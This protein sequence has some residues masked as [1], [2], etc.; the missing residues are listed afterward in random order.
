VV[1]TPAPPAVVVVYEDI[2]AY[3]L[4]EQALEHRA[5]HDDLTDLPNRTLFADRLEQAMRTAAREHKALAVIIMDLDRFKD[6]NDTFGHEYGDHLLR[7]VGQR[8]RETVRQS[9]T[10]A[11]MGGDEFGI[12]L[13]GITQRRQATIAARKVLSVFET[14]FE[15]EGHSL[16]VGASLGIAMFPLHAQDGRTAL[17]LADLAMYQA[18]RDGGGYAMY[19][20]APSDTEAR[21]RV[22][23]MSG[24]RQALER[25]ELILFYQPKVTIATGEQAGVEALVR[26]QHPEHGLLSPD[27]FVPL[28]ERTGLTRSLTHWVINAALRQCRAWQQD[29]IDLTVAV[30]LTMRDLQDPELPQAIARLLRAYSLPAG[31]LAIELGES[32]ITAESVL[33]VVSRLADLGV[34]FSIDDFGSGYSALSY[35]NRLPIDEL[36]IQRSLVTNIIENEQE[37]LIVRSAV[38]LAHRLGLRVVAQGVEGGDVFAQ[39]AELGCDC[40]QGYFIA[41]PMPAAALEEWL[42]VNASHA[43]AEPVDAPNETATAMPEPS[44]EEFAP[45]GG[46]PI[47]T[48]L[49]RIGLF[50]LLSSRDLD[51]LAFHVQRRSFN[52]GDVIFRKEDSGYTL[53]SIAAGAVKIA[54]PG[55]EG[56]E[57][58]LAI[59]RSGQFFGELSLF[60]DQPRSADA[61]AVE[62]TELLALSRED[63]L[64]VLDRRPGVGFQLLKILAARIRATNET[65]QDSAMLSLQARV[66]KRLLD[67]AHLYGERTAE[68][69]RIPLALGANEIA[70]MIG[71]QPP[72]VEATLRWYLNDGLIA[73]DD[74]HYVLKREQELQAISLD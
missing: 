24:F 47:A 18:K 21:R 52:N 9:D 3:K 71:A 4:T 5:L 44:R 57:V 72:E 31:A 30:N 60:D 1:R 68:G 6:V 2:T 41:P 64:A 23:L 26:W 25:D 54:V 27:D 59:L 32:E 38:D 70:G 74:G 63:L 58:I 55:A 40:G 10:L 37:A 39:L 43:N 42:R 50:S 28:V 17:R 19:E 45:G 48:M 49:S 22:T 73:R 14:P 20:P 46:L 69:I 67:M 53:Y 15:I 13:T 62:Q 33:E 7:Q 34:R 51:E 65:L 11:R 36:K 16:D 12:L 66:A 8:I 29:G 61:V 35:L 56:N